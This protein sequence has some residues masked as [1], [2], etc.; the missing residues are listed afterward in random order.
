[1]K[2]LLKVEVPVILG[3]EDVAILPLLTAAAD[4][5]EGITITTSTGFNVDVDLV[6]IERV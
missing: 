2:L 5:R 6:D 3:D 4:V 1:M